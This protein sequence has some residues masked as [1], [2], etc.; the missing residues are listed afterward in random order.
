MANKEIK[1]TQDEYYPIREDLL[2]A[3]ERYL[4]HGI[5]P[6]SFLTAVLENNLCEAFSRADHINEKNMKNIMGYIY[7]RIPLNAWGSREKVEKY[8]MGL[9]ERP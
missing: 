3:L 5:M 7:N 4:N 8:L 1:L 2:G 9:K 6:G